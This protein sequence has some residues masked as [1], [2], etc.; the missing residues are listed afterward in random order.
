MKIR[1]GAY[2]N[3]GA[4]N[5]DHVNGCAKISTI[6]GVQVD[7]RYNVLRYNV[8]FGYN[9]LFLI[10]RLGAIGLLYKISPL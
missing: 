5:F 2:F 7:S 4:E 8:L 9:V 3:P 1:A 10:P 6:P